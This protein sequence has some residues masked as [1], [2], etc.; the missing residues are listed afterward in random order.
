MSEISGPSLSHA[1]DRAGAG[2]KPEA[3]P[4]RAII[5]GSNNMPR[6][7]AEGPMSSMSDVLQ[8]VASPFREFGAGA[9]LLYAI[10]RALARVSGRMRL[11]VYELMVQPIGG[12]L[13]VA[14]RMAPLAIREILPG[15]PE[16]ARMPVRPEIMA[17]RR[18]QQ[19][20]CLGGFR[21][22][23]LVGYL[24]FARG[25]YAEDEVRC[26]YALPAGDGSVFDFDFYLFPEHR[27]GTAFVRLWAGASAYLAERGIHCSF[28]RMTR[29]NE[30]SRRAH[31]HLGARRVGRALFLRLGRFE[32]M[33]STLAP[34]LSASTRTRVRLRLPAPTTTRGS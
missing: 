25:S 21:D 1:A 11:H 9:G 27:M 26:T 16:V 29:F 31:R 13:P 12:T 24:W 17:A 8:R 14:R 34:Y 23:V 32:C 3:G 28:S 19:A 18:A 20:T 22:G 15:D 33:A 6:M 7:P 10:D 30:A 2:H 4:T 5:E